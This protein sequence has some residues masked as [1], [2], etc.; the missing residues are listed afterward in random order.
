MQT[1]SQQHLDLTLLFHPA[2]EGGFTVTCPE[3]P[4]LTTEG[5]TFEEARKMAEEAV[6]L[7]LNCMKEQG[8]SFPRTAPVLISTF[9]IPFPH[10]LSPRRVRKT[11]AA[12]IAA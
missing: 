4:G 12:R 5:D 8:E 10:G 2:E 7:Y 1:L 3:L 11:S 9:T 6:H